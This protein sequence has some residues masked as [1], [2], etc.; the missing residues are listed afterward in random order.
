[1]YSLKYGYDF[2]NILIY[3]E[4]CDGKGLKYEYDSFVDILWCMDIKELNKIQNRDNLLDMLLNDN[5]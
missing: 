5:I 2:S 1:M 3:K 4:V